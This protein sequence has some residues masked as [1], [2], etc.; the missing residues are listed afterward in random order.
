MNTDTREYYSKTDRLK[1][2]PDLNSET[3]LNSSYLGTMSIK[4]YPIPQ[5]MWVD[6]KQV[7]IVEID[8]SSFPKNYK[9][10]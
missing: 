1:N 3:L 2:I 7:V 4:R 10:L 8:L 9:E 5:Y 6:N